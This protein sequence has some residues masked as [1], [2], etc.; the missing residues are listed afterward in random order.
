MHKRRTIINSLCYSGCLLLLSATTTLAAPLLTLEEVV[1]IVLQHNFDVKIACN[2]QRIAA[3]KYHLGTA[4]FLPSLDVKLRGNDR[5]LTH[6]ERKY[7]DGASLSAGTTLNWRLFSGLSS[8]YYY[9][10]LGNRSQISQLKTAQVVVDQVT[11]ATKRYYTLAVAQ[12]KKRVS[13]NSLAVSKEVLQLTE[14]KYKVGKCTRLDYL[15]AQVQHNEEQVKLLLLEEETT[16]AK[17][18]LWILLGENALEDFA[19]VEAIPPPTLLDWPSL[20]EAFTTGNKSIAISQ[21]DCENAALDVQLQQAKLWPTVDFSFGYNLGSSYQKDRWEATP[22]GFRGG[23]SVSFNLFHAFQHS[24]DIQVA[25]IQVDSAHV[26]LAKQQT[27]LAAAFRELFLQ[28]TQQLQRYD[29]A[30]QHLQLSQENVALALEQY[31]L[32]GITLLALHQ[33]RKTAQETTVR[34]LQAIYDAKVTELELWRLAGRLP[35]AAH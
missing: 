24:T 26:G 10:H 35:G 1:E 13:E 31:R 4:G 11:K 8:L 23:I 3:E 9:E 12:G 20:E 22:R 21:K 18:N 17:L 7:R 2:K 29:L 6:P 15:T 16:K 25:G 5:F 14:A 32:G 27:E 30:L 19:V 33:A 34:S 28:H